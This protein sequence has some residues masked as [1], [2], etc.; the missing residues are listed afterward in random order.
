L[1]LTPSSNSG[2]GGLGSGGKTESSESLSSSSSSSDASSSAAASDGGGGG[3]DEDE[4][5]VPRET[6]QVEVCGSV[7]RDVERRCPFFIKGTENDKAAGN[8]SFICKGRMTN[9]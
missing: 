2:S 8:P 7:C 5:E 6:V 3:A 4:V 9:L 1:Y